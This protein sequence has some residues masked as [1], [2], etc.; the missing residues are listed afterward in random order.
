[1]RLRLNVVLTSAVVTAIGLL[2]LLGLLVG[3]NLEPLTTLVTAGPLPIRLIAE[4]LLRLTVVTV[5]LAVV[6]GVLNLMTVHVSRLVRGPGRMTR[7]G[8]LV[9]LLAFLGTVL[10]YLIDAQG[11]ASRLLLDRVQVT[12]ESGLAALLCFALIYGACLVLLRRPTVY[13][14][15]FVATVLI[16]LVSALP[17][18]G[19]PI[20]EDASR[21]LMNVPVNAGARGILIGIALA[22]IVAG[23]RVL[24]GQDR[25]YGA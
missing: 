19:V 8:S 21:W 6:L 11:Q 16:V 9:L 22:T 7:L 23:V 20:L 13:G 15:L 24:I 1:M 2:T 17:I 18:S 14:A 10:L 3:D 5:S 12:L 25:S 4:L